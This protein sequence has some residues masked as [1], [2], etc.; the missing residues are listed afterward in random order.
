M[1]FSVG[2][3]I[4]VALIVEVVNDFIYLFLAFESILCTV[5]KE[6]MES[7]QPMTKE[8]WLLLCVF[9]IFYYRNENW[10]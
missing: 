4:T 3:P 7:L 1:M 9:E 5:I 8:R 10:A 2:S 6:E